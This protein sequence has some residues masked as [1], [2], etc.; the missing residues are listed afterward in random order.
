VES[1]AWV[2]FDLF[3]V[4]FFVTGKAEKRIRH[5]GFTKTAPAPGT[6]GVL[7]RIVHATGGFTYKRAG[8]KKGNTILRIGY[9]HQEAALANSLPATAKKEQVVS[10]GAVILAH[11]FVPALDIRDDLFY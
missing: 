5:A 2:I 11:H 1:A 3:F 8:L 10:Y 4:N 6:I 7:L 9:H